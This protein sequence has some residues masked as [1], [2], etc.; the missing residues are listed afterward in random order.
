MVHFSGRYSSRS[1]SARDPSLAA[2]ARNTP[3]CA[4]TLPGVPVYCRATPAHIRPFFRKPVSSTASTADG[5][6]R[7]FTTYC[8][9]RPAPRR[10]PRRRS[11]AAAASRPVIH[12]SANPPASTRSSAPRGR[13]QAQHV[14]PRPLP[15][16]CVLEL[17]RH[18]GKHLIEP[19]RPRGMRLTRPHPR[20]IDIPSSIVPDWHPRQTPDHASMLRQVTACG[21][22]TRTAS[23]TVAVFRIPLVMGSL[24]VVRCQPV[25]GYIAL[26]P[27]WSCGVSRSPAAA[28]SR[29]L[30]WCHRRG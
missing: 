22:S 25:R 19:L 20:L 21:C 3:T 28:R 5:S 11:S 30:W 6:P 15:R 23:I 29:A 12:P 1:I 2:Y 13:Q 10:R 17:A 9:P 24:C 27:S 14:G 18:L 7:F 8:A 4:P 16:A 26:S